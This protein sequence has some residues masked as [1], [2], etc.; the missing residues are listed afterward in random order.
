MSHEGE[1]LDNLERFIRLN[2]EQKNEFYKIIHFCRESYIKK[3]VENTKSAIEIH[4]EI[5]DEYIKKKRISELIIFL[6]EAS[7]DEYL[8]NEKLFIRQVLVELNRKIHIASNQMTVFTK[9]IAELLEYNH[10]KE[11]LENSIRNLFSDYTTSVFPYIYELSLSNTQSRRSRAGKTF[12]FIIYSLYEKFN[13]RF[14]SQAKIGKKVFKDQNL[15]KIVDSVLPSVNAFVQLRNKTIVGSMKTTL[16]ERWQEVVEEVSRSNL[17]NIYLL[18]VDDNI[19]ESKIKQMGEHNIILVVL[20]QIKETEKL[21]S[22]RN[23]ISFEDYF[24]EEIPN[25]LSYWAQRPL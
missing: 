18:T 10:N 9:L 16:R 17:P 25:I 24:L 1:K 7:Y 4:T 20:K 3:P 2:T 11:N 12:E 22:Y 13:Y 23:V 14:D 21:L 8:V 6:R 15:G 5:I 19:S